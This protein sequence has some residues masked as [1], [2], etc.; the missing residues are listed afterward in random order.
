MSLCARFQVSMYSGYYVC[1]H[2]MSQTDLQTDR[3]TVFVQVI[4][5]AQLVG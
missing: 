4:C 5:I 1:H 2:L 3:Q